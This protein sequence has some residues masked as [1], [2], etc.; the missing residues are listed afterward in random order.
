MDAETYI[1][2]AVRTLGGERDQVS[3]RFCDNFDT[4]IYHMSLVITEIVELFQFVEN[5]RGGNFDSANFLEECGDILWYLAIADAS[6]CLDGIT[7]RYN[8]TDVKK[9]EDVDEFLDSV[10]R[11]TI[12]MTA[13][14]GKIIDIFGK[15]F[16]FYGRQY[17]VDKIISLMQSINQSVADVLIEAG[18]TIDDA[19]ESNINK[20]KKRY[21][22]KFTESE[23]NHRNHDAEVKA[24]EC[25][26]KN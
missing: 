10:M 19:R 3:Q 25:F 8:Q 14:A 4:Q 16:L 20:L 6:M 1:E 5:A 11:R 21:A 2:N 15:K 23:A 26:L 9:I 24:V 17:D 12:S 7:M 13:A 18:Y 22:E